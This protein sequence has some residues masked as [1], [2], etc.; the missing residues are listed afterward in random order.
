MK[1]Q[2]E[3][4]KSRTLSLFDWA[5][6]GV[7][8]WILN[9][10]VIAK[11]ETVDYQPGVIK[12]VKPL[13][14][15]VSVVLTANNSEQ[16]FIEG[17][18]VQRTLDP[19]LVVDLIEI[20]IL[21]E[22]EMLHHFALAFQSNEIYCHCGPA[23]IAINP[24]QVIPKTV[25][26]ENMNKLIN[27]VEKRKLNEADPHVW[28]VAA[29]AY[30]DLEDHK[31]SQSICINGE[32]GSGKTE[33]IK[34]CLY[35]LTEVERK[36]GKTDMRDLADRILACDPILESFGNCTTNN[37][38]NSSRFGKYLSLFY[39]FDSGVTLIGAEM[40]NYLLEKTRVVSLDDGERSFHVFYAMCKASP[41]GFQKQ[42]LLTQGD[43]PCDLNTFGLFRQNSFHSN[44][45]IDDAQVWSEL[46][47]AFSTL[48]FKAFE[49]DSLWRILSV[50]LHLSSLEVDSSHYEEGRV[51]C[52]IVEDSH[53]QAVLQLLGCP[54][55]ETQLALTTRVRVVREFLS[56]KSI[57]T[58]HSPDNV[59]NFINSLAKE[60]YFKLFNWLFRKLN[61]GIKGR[62][63][64]NDSKLRS[65]GLLDIYGFEVGLTNTLNQLL[66]N[67]TN[68]K[69]QNVFITHVF[70]NECKKF[71]DEGLQDHIH[72]ITF[73]DNL[74]LIRAID[75]TVV[76]QGIFGLL[77]QVCTLNQT[78]ANFLTN[79]QTLAND[80]TFALKSFVHFMPMKRNVF[81]VRHS[82]KEVDY[83]VSGFVEQ[84]KDEVPLTITALI[85]N[86][87]PAI[88]DVYNQVVDKIETASPEG[89]WSKEK[90][91]CSKFSTGINGLM[92]KLS[93]NECH[94]VRCVKPNNGKLKQLF[95]HDVVLRQITYMGLLDSLRIRKF[96]YHNR[97]AYPDFYNTYQDLDS[98]T[99]GLQTMQ[100]LKQSRVSFR[101]LSVAM[102]Q[103]LPI[104]LS[105]NQVLF[106]TSIVFMND[107]I[108]MQLNGLLEQK[109]LAKKA[110]V[111]L[112]VEAF[113]NGVKRH[114]VR[115][116]VRSHSRRI[117]LARDV[118]LNLEARVAHRE[119]KDKMQAIRKVQRAVR[120][121]MCRQ[122]EAIRNRQLVTLMSL[123][124]VGRLSR[125]LKEFLRRRRLAVLVRDLFVVQTMRR[126]RKVVRRVVAELV[127]RAW[128]V[129]R[130]KSADSAA[131]VVQSSF[132]S[133]LLRKD[134][135]KQGADLVKHHKEYLHNH[136]ASLIQA[137]ARGFL[138]RKRLSRLTRAVRKV[139]GLVRTK[140]LQGYVRRIRWSVRVIQRF[141]RRCHTRAKMVGQAN[142]DVA[143][144]LRKFKRLMLVEVES[145]LGQRYQGMG[146]LEYLDEV[147]QQ[148]V[149]G[150]CTGSQA[151]RKYIPD[152]LSVEVSP[153]ARLFSVPLDMCFS[154]SVF[155]V[156][157]RTWSREFNLLVESMHK[158]DE[159]LLQ[160][161]AGGSFTM[162]VSDELKVY[163][164][165]SNDRRQLGQQLSEGL[166]KP[167][168]EVA[169]LSKNL[170]MK[171]VVAE[172]KCALITQT[173]RAFFWGGFKHSELSLSDSD[174][175]IES[176]VVNNDVPELAIDLGVGGL[177]DSNGKH[178]TTVLGQNG[179]LFVMGTDQKSSGMTANQAVR[180]SLRHKSAKIDFFEF[181]NPDYLFQ[182]IRNQHPEWST[183]SQPPPP[184]V[185]LLN[186]VLQ[187]DPVTADQSSSTRIPICPVR[188][189]T[190]PAKIDSICCGNDFTLLL[191]DKGVVLAIGS[192]E[193]GQ[194]GVGD[195][196]K[197]EEMVEVELFRATR[198]RVVEV[199]CGFK[200]AVCRTHSGQLYGWG[201]GSYAQNG[202][203]QL[204]VRTQPTLIQIDQ[205]LTTPKA[206]PVCVQTT[207]FGSFVLFNDS[208]LVVFGHTG[209][210]V[211]RRP[212][213]LPYESML[214]GSRM[215]D[216]FVPV[217]ICS[218]WSRSVGVLMV[219]FVD[220][221][222]V[223][224]PESVKTRL[225][226]RV[227]AK[228]KRCNLLPHYDNSL[229]NWMS[230]KCFLKAKP[231][232][233][234]IEVNSSKSK[235]KR[236]K[237]EE[238]QVEKSKGKRSHSAVGEQA[239]HN[240]KRVPFEKTNQSQLQSGA[241]NSNR[242]GE[243][244]RQIVE[245]IESMKV[246]QE[247]V[248]ESLR[249]SNSGIV[250]LVDDSQVLL[251]KSSV[252]VRGVDEVAERG[253]VGRN[254][255]EWEHVIDS[256]GRRK[257][258]SKKRGWT[259]K[260]ERRVLGRVSVGGNRSVGGRSSI[261]GG[262]KG[263]AEELRM[264]SIGKRMSGGGGGTRRESSDRLG[265]RTGELG[266]HKG[267]RNSSEV[268][269]GNTGRDVLDFDDKR[270]IFKVDKQSN[271]VKYT[272]IFQE[273]KNSRVSRPL[274]TSLGEIERLTNELQK[275]RQKSKTQNQ[276][277]RKSIEK[278]KLTTNSSAK[279]G[280][281]GGGV[282]GK[283]EGR[284]EAEK[285]RR[286]GQVG[287]KSGEV[288]GG[289]KQ[290][291]KSREPNHA[292]DKLEVK[293][294]DGKE[295]VDSTAH[296]K[297]GNEETQPKM[298]EGNYRYSNHKKR[299]Q[300][301]QKADPET[302]KVKPEQLALEAVNR[303]INV[304]VQKILKKNPSKWTNIEKE[305]M[306]SY[307]SLIKKLTK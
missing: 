237:S 91:T 295:W 210:G 211:F 255:G 108:V 122:R 266:R 61:L 292:P 12:E 137:A 174:R 13:T 72:N 107:W 241:V 18:V 268:R 135:S 63:I 172:D 125:A 206:S 65:I 53:F 239:N 132:R 222:G 271:K 37:N 153:K 272:L 287:R 169:V 90:F 274:Q 16:D 263:K 180:A 140:W 250:H 245:R 246:Q 226:E 120:G 5:K 195:S 40:E 156:Y 217:R 79:L 46:N 96:N 216:G 171:A 111:K 270:E 201:N 115:E 66:I 260:E 145:C 187:S 221:R 231:V 184:S 163:T 225:S 85:L 11:V 32:S 129:V 48:N 25:S 4:A 10:K 300:H 253:E 139:Q 77:N 87:H 224:M 100:S 121:F 249:R 52:R 82:A 166:Y 236:R 247:R 55:E 73:Q 51:P 131:K 130:T 30:C 71:V 193:F 205:C 105:P 164:F 60:L 215:R 242:L 290:V 150:G 283:G 178:L 98:S 86:S 218:S 252:G 294:S 223:K 188:N 89:P 190:T 296:L 95:K 127:E 288:G 57:A 114:K 186:F 68:E 146:Q 6:P 280:W 92:D 147:H 9:K 240:S 33:S 88:A 110:A 220:V 257:S 144:R 31:A 143:D 103:S 298:E 24:Y 113:R 157:P 173:G 302:P 244:N 158:R 291:G 74:S 50:V 273:D 123:Y 209:Y 15:K 8:V 118:F 258:S 112:L 286:S 301:T 64:S 1:P 159:R 14:K 204:A 38:D 58:P 181:E 170:P 267:V 196:E 232:P 35:F 141:W 97:L 304:E 54:R 133:Y 198:Q 126:R 235:E 62:A 116:G 165:G 162:V 282:E 23:L 303:E 229:A 264:E 254:G 214:F 176:I 233:F 119:F 279:N 17:M 265:H 234:L 191:L 207:A 81:L 219:Q 281:E 56:S 183:P 230:N 19:H 34:K 148:W 161:V 28:T 197:R 80:S 276:E 179:S 306:S 106:G 251:G 289:G 138:V 70:K 192:N 293:G 175:L 261:E 26:A 101:E 142:Q 128:S 262:L 259:G 134:Y 154:P 228:W 20:P 75:S 284:G 109:Q 67:Y 99:H 297:K 160:V 42:Y 39:A 27:L 117:V 59:R 21:N 102:M 93:L 45:N 155:E 182:A 78:D 152:Q 167:A 275:V 83:A 3:I 69:L 199:V 177:R 151:V 213:R 202:S 278:G 256:S 299:T 200:H 208:S 248:R 7:P 277:I 189:L 36:S 104:D 305:I 269:L 22:A 149:A 2:T 168:H 194:L 285:G 44:K 212:A 243:E 76:P 307:G 203:M 47:Q 94:F 41:L 124:R 43:R 49:Q 185:K 84:N 227:L 136:S 29:H 238:K